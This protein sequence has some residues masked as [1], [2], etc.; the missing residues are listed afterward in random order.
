M[1]PLPDSWVDELLGRMAV[2]YGAKFTALYRDIDPA[3]VRADWA[4]CLA[5]FSD[6]PAAL[7]QA[8]EWLPADQP[9]NAAQ[10]R[11]LAMEAVPKPQ[12]LPAPQAVNYGPVPDRVRRVLEQAFTP[13]DDKLTPNQRM[14]QNLR[15]IRDSG[16]RLT[17]AQADAIERCE[18]YERRGGPSS[19]VG[20]SFKPIPWEQWPESMRRDYPQPRE[21]AA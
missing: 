12:A 1:Q 19:T 3:A 11:A 7:A 16:A 18:A 5:W 9:P 17:A 21:V 14:L 2:R 4:R 20:G 8:L 13:P 6:K 10:F 15:R